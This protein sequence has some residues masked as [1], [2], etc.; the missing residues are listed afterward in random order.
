M[1]ICKSINIV[2][3]FAFPDRASHYRPTPKSLNIVRSVV[4]LSE[5]RANSIIATYGSG[6]SLSALIG[7]L[8]VEADHDK[9]EALKDVGTRLRDYDSSISTFLENRMARRST[10]FVL[11]LN[12][13]VADLRSEIARAL[14]LGKEESI[15]TILKRVETW[16]K[17][18]GFDS[19]AIIWDEFGRHLE[20]LV[21]NARAEELA[22][23]QDLAE[24]VVRRKNPSA[25]LTLLLHQ[26]FHQFAGRLGQTD[27]TAWKKIEGRFNTIRIIEDSDEIYRFIASVVSSMMPSVKK[28]VSAVTVRITQELDLFPFIENEAEMKKFLELAMPLSPSA[29]YLL[30]KI[31]GRV[32]QSER[33]IFGFLGNQALENNSI[34]VGTEDIYRYFSEAMRSDIGVGG[35]YKR[36]IETESARSRSRSNIECEVLGVT[37]LLHLVGSSIGGQVSRDK[38]LKFVQLGSNHR[39]KLIGEAIDTLLERKLLIHRKLADEVSVWHGSDID[40]RALLHEK[41]DSLRSAGTL[42]KHIQEQVPKPFYFAAEYNYLNSI[43]RFAPGVFVEV[44]DLLNSKRRAS[45]ISWANENDA[46]VALVVNGTVEDFDQINCDWLI[47]TP[48][49]IVALPD[50]RT[51]LGNSCLEVAA[52]TELLSDEDLIAT[53]PLVERELHDLR[54]S[55]VEYLNSRVSYLTN[56]EIGGVSW[57]SAGEC[58]GHGD[59]INVSYVLSR[60]FDMRF[61]LTPKVINEQIVRRR[62]TPQ[63]KSARKRLLLGILERSRVSNMGYLNATTADASIYRT[64]LVATGLYDS[65][66]KTWSLP[67]QIVDPAMASVWRTLQEFYSQPAKSPKRFSEIIDKLS[68][69]PY[70]IRRGLLPILLTAGLRAFGEVVAIRKLVKEWIY[71][72]DIQPTTMEEICDSPELF[73]IEV[74]KVS[75][76]EKE[77]V[78]QATLE[79]SAIPDLVENDVIRAF[80]DALRS[81]KR[82]LPLAALQSKVSGEAASNLQAAMRQTGDDPVS[83]LFRAL[84]SIAGRKRFDSETLTYVSE[85][86]R[87]IEQVTLKYVE[88]AIGLTRQ[89]FSNGFV[90]CNQSLLYCAEKW[91]SDIPISVTSDPALDHVSKGILNR[92]R[93]TNNE[94]DSEASFVRAL[95]AM[96]VGLDFEEWDDRIATRYIRELQI[97]IREIEDTALNFGN[98]KKEL[99]PFLEHKIEIYFN[100]LVDSAGIED[101]KAFISEL[102]GTMK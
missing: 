71:V 64:T 7:G 24:W 9:I 95:S 102:E 49:L 10:G 53:D 46:L 1:T 15:T 79:F 45:L 21:S 39:R 18:R 72:D 84:P 40:I 88:S 78:R 81:W 73:E 89:A 69:P 12:G 101:A 20:G 61:P 2:E 56:P 92:A 37:G 4:G 74:I 16:L 68:C 5:S 41:I 29:L 6:K 35:T 58:L 38:L 94:R 100:K 67:E 3:D 34:L 31:A 51:D 30:P 76:K 44:E 59:E 82:N 60:L 22:Y 23:V 93:R 96:L 87:Q 11:T 52:L 8:I 50:Q 55:A 86:R 25:T 90:E 77:L 80:Y 32:G 43:T 48:H 28:R 98:G 19:I 66:K 70:G 54:G 63:A 17:K 97:R 99:T 85:A 83:L 36:F 33:T 14:G 13:Y 91:A 62:I 47:E 42:V 57:F 75:G 27:K 26:E 65:E